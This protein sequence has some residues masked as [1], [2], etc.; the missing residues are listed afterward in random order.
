MNM[1]E[2]ELSRSDGSTAIEFGEVRLDVPDQTVAARPDLKAYEGKRVIVGIRPEDME[3]ASLVSDAPPGRRIRS[4]VFLREALGADV[5]VHFR[6]KVPPVLTEDARELADDV[7]Q[8][9]VAAVEQLS[10]AGESTFLA[11]LNPRTDARERG[12]I[13]L[14]VDTNRFHF[15]DPETGLGIYGG[16]GSRGAGR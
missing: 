3:D 5:L 9:A 4:T 10:R 15:F 2:A 14:V 1:V 13:E 16:N 8:E 11:R 7:G 12:E 6:I